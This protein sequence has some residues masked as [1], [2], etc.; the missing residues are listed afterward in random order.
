VLIGQPPPPARHRSRWPIYAGAAATG[1]FAA[2]AVVLTVTSNGLYDD[3]KTS[4]GGTTAGCTQAQIDVVK[5][6]DRA[7]T[8]LWILAGAAAVA[9]SVLFV[10]RF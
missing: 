10:L 7:A 3:L 4:C 8:A 2:G 6:R 1:A 9:T 5:T